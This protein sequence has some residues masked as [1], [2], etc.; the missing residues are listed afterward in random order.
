MTRR[1]EL[2]NILKNLPGVS[3]AYFQPPATVKMTYPCIVY[4]LNNMDTQFAD[5][6]PYVIRKGYTVTVIDPD[7]DSK[8]PDYVSKLK[9]CRFD[10]F[11]TVD[12]LNHFI[13][14]LY[15]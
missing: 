14:K 7:P 6:N 13:F 1:M 11:F 15:Y 2:H 8:I 3:K 10:R 9:Y 12:N 5:D 4:E